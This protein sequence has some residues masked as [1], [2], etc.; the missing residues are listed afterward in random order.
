MPKELDDLAGDL[1]T[2]I[3][4]ISKFLGW[5]KR[6]TYYE[7]E[8]GRL[9]LFKVG[10]RIWCGRKSTLRRHIEKLEAGRV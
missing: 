6:R 9:P 8:K 10:E 2:G 4:P 7:A 1:M 5:P 3:G